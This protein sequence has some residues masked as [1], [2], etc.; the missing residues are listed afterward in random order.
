MIE[1]ILGQISDDQ[2]ATA[3][4]LFAPD[5]DGAGQYRATGGSPAEMYEQ[6]RSDWLFRMP[7][8]HL[9]EA[10]TG[11]T[12]MYELTW[13][14]PGMGAILGACHGL[15]VP[16]VFGNLTSG[17]PAML[18]GGDVAEAESLSAEMRSAWTSFANDGNPG[19]PAFDLETRLTRVFGTGLTR[20]F[21]TDSAVVAYPEEDSRRIWENHAFSTLPLITQR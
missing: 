8:L 20:V 2:A 6:V 18:L 11:R 16:L 3:L 13:P 1:G 14:A 17:Q 9:A 21:G 5:P 4:D 7:S 10:H 12:Y 15:D 19:W